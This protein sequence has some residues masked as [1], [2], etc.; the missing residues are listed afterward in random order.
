[1]A[2]KTDGSLWAWG[3]NSSGQLG[4]GTTDNK[5]SPIQ[6]GTD[7]DWA[8]V[9]ASLLH[10]TALKTDGSLWAWGTNSSGQLGDGE[11]TGF[12][13]I[14]LKMMDSVS[15]VSAGAVHTM[16]IK[17]DGSLWAWGLNDRGQIGDGTTQDRTFPVKI[18][19][20]VASVSAGMSHTMAIQTDGSLWAWGTNNAGQLGDGTTAMN[21]SIPVRIMDTKQKTGVEVGICKEAVDM[22]SKRAVSIYSGY[23]L[24]EDALLIEKIGINELGMTVC[25]AEVVVGGVYLPR[26]TQLMQ[27]IVN[28]NNGYFR[29]EYA[30]IGGLN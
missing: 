3:T 27:Y 2:I 1:M 4:D 10:T 29:V 19:D 8:S 12:R 20:S 23:V 28:E 5:Y 9:S 22:A 16:V 15:S 26:Q 13:A 14:P 6:I 24:V 11:T 21:R 7:T 25:Q 30:G 18:M 17:T